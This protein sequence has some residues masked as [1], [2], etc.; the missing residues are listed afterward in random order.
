M[1]ILIFELEIT[2]DMVT[3]M[4]KFMIRGGVIMTKS[5][6]IKILNEIGLLLELKGENFFKSR[7]YYDAANK[8]EVIQEDIQTLVSENRLGSIKGFGKAL[9]SKITELV[10]TGELE[11]YTKLKET[12]PKGLVSMLRISGL[13]PKK[14][15]TIYKSLGVNTIEELKEACENNRL[16]DL[17]RFSKK[18][19]DKILEGIKN[20][21][22]Y[23]EK[24]H[25]P[26][27]EVLSSELLKYIRES[28]IVQRCEVAGSL[29][30]KKEVLKDIDLLV[31]SDEPDKV[32]DLFTSHYYVKE[33][34]GKGE[35][36][37][38]VVLQNGMNADIR[39]V[40]DSQF[41][42]ALHHFTGSKEHN[43]A[44]RHIAKKQGI[45]MNEY[46]LFK[47]DELI[48]CHN[49]KDIFNVF[50]M[51]FIPPELRENYGELEA[52]ENKELPVLVTNEDVRG[53]F[54]THTNYSDGNA[55]IEQLVIDCINR[56]Y[57]Y[58]G[59]TDHSKTAIYA[60]GLTEEDIKR[61]HEEIDLL[62]EKYND[63][64][65]L[66]G[67][68]SDILPDGS[69]DYDE[70]I[71]QSFDFIIGSVHSAFKMEQKKMT[72]RIIKAISNPYM[73][74]LGHPTGRLL[75]S[76][77]G[78]K[79]DIEQIIEACIENDIVIEINANPYRLDLDWRH[80]K[81]AKEKGC[82]FVISP[83]AHSPKEFDYMRYGI[84]VARKGWLEKSDIINT[85]KK[86]EIVKYFL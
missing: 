52:A 82:K 15:M 49:E 40:S 42:Y 45:K 38:S 64:K 86:D 13:G 78:Y 28:G 29:R 31:S 62:N 41:P 68:E 74:I 43:T 30:R 70:R 71:L 65:I 39:V 54:H 63:F 32:M 12:V 57:S 53:V 22:E 10:T 26:I 51:E 17:P 33:I 59:I 61:Q 5:E 18:T 36:K 80:M 46:G 24:F 67:I 20:Y 48:V 4:I 23:S 55:T 83:D 16:L 34:T 37:S 2:I 73:S 14:I 1:L 7:A 47:D 44:L 76:R 75:L 27:G 58:L 9:T 66:K 19:Q 72:D 21:N 77:E 11:Y 84:N 85:L 6:V 35:T 69:L 60:G 25:Y 8:L 3:N 81:N 50:G 56:G 79:I